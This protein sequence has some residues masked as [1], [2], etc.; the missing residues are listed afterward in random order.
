[1][2]AGEWRAVASAPGY[3]VSKDGRVWS[4]R[5]GRLLS[6]LLSRDGY[7]KVQ[8]SLMGKKPVQRFVHRLV[9]EAF[10][11]GRGEQ[12]RHLD[13]NKS[14]NAAENLAWGTCQQNILDKW[15]HGKMVIGER[16]HCAKVPLDAIPLIRASKESN[17]VLGERYG[18]TRAAI[19][20]IRKGASY[21][22]L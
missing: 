5:R 7:R 17:T 9:A 22:W 11:D 3:W 19:Y 14:N 6:G 8:L 18:V 13:G 20:N 10:L 1:M 4:D 12:V 2:P 15:D 16:H 21:G